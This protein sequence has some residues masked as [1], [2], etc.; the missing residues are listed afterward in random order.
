M[1]TGSKAFS[2]IGN[3]A[4]FICPAPPIR[5]HQPQRSK[6]AFSSSIVKNCFSIFFY[7]LELNNS[8][9]DTGVVG[10]LDRKTL[11]IL[12]AGGGQHVHEL[13]F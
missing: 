7:V 9:D 5:A 13:L 6:K 3:F 12:C 1:L 11:D 8:G 4:P 10:G 2:A